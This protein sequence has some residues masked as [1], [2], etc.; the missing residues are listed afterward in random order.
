MCVLV[1][2]LLASCFY[3]TFMSKVEIAHRVMQ[4]PMVL[5]SYSNVKVVSCYR[6]VLVMLTTATVLHLTTFCHMTFTGVLWNRR[7]SHL[8]RYPSRTLY[9]HTIATFKKTFE[10]P[11]QN[12]SLPIHC[13]QKYTL[14][15][16]AHYS[17]NL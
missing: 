6:R 9:S 8:M 2:V 17:K 15:I 1:Q 14:M 13:I 10:A 7:L 3:R 16:W 11:K 4:L 12:V 5:K